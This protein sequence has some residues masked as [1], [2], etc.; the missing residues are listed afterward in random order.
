[1]PLEFLTPIIGDYMAPIMFLGLVV[2][3]LSGYQIGRA[4]V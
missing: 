4:H 1:M 3:L 2:F